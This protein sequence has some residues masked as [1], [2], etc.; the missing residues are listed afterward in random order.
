M[1]NST[2]RLYNMEVN[3]SSMGSYEASQIPRVEHD[4]SGFGEKGFICHRCNPKD[5]IV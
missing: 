5:I 3:N 1:D 4:C 2:N